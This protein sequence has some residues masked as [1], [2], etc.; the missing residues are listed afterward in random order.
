MHDWIYYSASKTTS[1]TQPK[2]FLTQLK[3][4]FTSVWKTSG[5]LNSAPLNCSNNV[6]VC[7]CYNA[8]SLYY[9][10]GCNIDFVPDEAI[11]FEKSKP[12][13][14]RGNTVDGYERL[15]ELRASLKQNKVGDET[16]NLR[17]SWSVTKKIFLFQLLTA[18]NTNILFYQMHTN[19]YND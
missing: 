10:E 17:Q 9:S 11:V 16:T 18:N 6:T 14:E 19:R 8:Y 2:K 13:R 15:Q 1:R 12:G 3:R 5:S 7:T 4:R